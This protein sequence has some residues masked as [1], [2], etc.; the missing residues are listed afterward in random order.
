MLFI[1]EKRKRLP[2]A[3]SDSIAVPNLVVIV[4]IVG[5]AVGV[6]VGVVVAV[7]QW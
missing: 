4:V 6:V 3:N 5:V 7:L 1:K 2:S